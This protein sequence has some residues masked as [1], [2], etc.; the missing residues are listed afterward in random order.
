MSR[1]KGY[2]RSDKFRD[3]LVANGDALVKPVRPSINGISLEKGAGA[4]SI[5]EPALEHGQGSLRE[6]VREATSKLSKSKSPHKSRC[7]EERVT[8]S[9]R[10]VSA[11]F[12]LPR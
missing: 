2:A 5:V 4:C 7:F 10:F 11:L 3:L 12:H 1:R 9:I 6:R 8:A